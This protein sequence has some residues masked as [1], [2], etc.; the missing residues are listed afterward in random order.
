MNS[1]LHKAALIFFT[2]VTLAGGVALLYRFSEFTVKAEAGPV[3]DGSSSN[4]RAAQDRSRRAR[5]SENYGRLPL[6]F[7]LNDGQFA[8]DV[9][10]LSRGSGYNL[11][12]T[13]TE[14]VLTLSKSTDESPT[15]DDEEAI[16]GRAKRLRAKRGTARETATVR[17]KL[18]GS[19]D[20]AR[21]SGLGELPGKVNYF[22]GG[23]ASKWR[24][25]IST[26]EKV[27]YES[28][29]SGVDVIY[30]GNQR[31]L[32]YD[33]I[34]AP[35]AD[36]R[37][38]KLDFSGVDKIEITANGDLV[39]HVGDDRIKQHKSVVYQE[40]NG[41]RR[42]IESSYVITGERRVGFALGQYD[43]QKPLVI[44]P[45]LSYS[46]YLGGSAAESGNSITVD[47]SGHAYITGRTASPDFPTENPVQGVGSGNDVFV[48]KLNP[49]GT[50]LIFSTYIGGGIND[51]GNGIA[52]DPN[53]NIYIAGST[54]SFNFPTAGTPFQ[55]AK[56]GVV[57][58]LYKSFDNG[59][60]FNPS[61]NGLN[62]TTVFSIALHPTD[63]S[64]VFAGTSGGVVPVYR[65]TDGGVNWVPSSNG[66]PIRPV[67]RIIFD[68]T[69]PSIMYNVGRGI[70]VYKSTNGGASWFASSTGLSLSGATTTTEDLVI[71]SNNPNTLYVCGQGGVYKST[72]AGQ[73]WSAVNNGLTDT[74]G[75]NVQITI[76]LAVDPRTSAVYAGTLAGVYRSTDG[77]N[78]VTNNQP[79]NQ[80]FPVSAGDANS[81]AINAATNPSTLYVGTE[82]GV[83][84]STDGLNWTPISNGLPATGIN[85]VAIDPRT[86][87]TTLY[88]ATFSNGVYKSIDDGL[89]WTATNLTNV[90]VLPLALDTRTAPASLYAGLFTG[91]DAFVTK[92]NPTGSALIYSTYLGGGTE[93]ISSADDIAF[94]IAV[95]T[96]GNAYVTG[97]TFTGDFPTQN[98]LQSSFGDNSF[99]SGFVT[100]L[101]S[102]GSS[103]IYSTYLKGN[104]DRF[105]GTFVRDI[106]RGIAV[107]GSGNA[108]VTGET[109]AVDFP[110][111]NAR[112]STYGGGSSDAFVTAYNATGSAYLYS[113]YLGGSGADRGRSIAVDTS[114]N[115]YV[116]GETSSTNFPT[117][118][119]LQSTYGG[120][121]DAFVTKYNSSGSAYIF[122]TYLGG[123]GI[124]QG[125][126]IAA[127]SGGNS[128]VTGVTASGTANTPN[129]TGAF[130]T[131]NALQSIRAGGND[132]FVSKLNATGNSLVYSTYLG[133]SGNDQGNSIALDSG[134]NA[135]V[136]GQTFSFNFPTTRDAFSSFFF[137]S[138]NNITNAFVSKISESANGFQLT[139]RLVTNA[140]AP[141]ADAFI[142]LSDGAGLFLNDTRTDAN[143]FYQFV[144]V[145]PGSYIVTPNGGTPVG[146]FRFAPPSAR[147]DNVSSDQRDINFTGTRVF[148]ISGSITDANNPQRGI[149][150]IIVTLSGTQSA[151]ATT[152]A[153]GFYEFSDLL[154]G[155]N[156]TVTPSRTSTTGV[157]YTFT[158]PNRVYNNLQSD[159]FASFTT[160]S[161]QFF[162]VSGRVTDAGG[163]PI[164]GANVVLS[165]LRGAFTPTDANGNYAFANLQEG[166][167]YTVKVSKPV[168]VFTP[169]RGDVPP[170]SGNATVN[171]TAAPAT[172][173]IS[174]IA[175]ERDLDDPNSQSFQ[176]DIFV[177]NANGTGETNLTNTPST[178]DFQPAWSP[179]GTRLAF[180]GDRDTPGVGAD[181]YTMN[182]D[183]TNVTRVTNTP[184]VNEENPTW[185]PDGTRLAF[186]ADDANDDEED[187]IFV[188][189]ADG[190]NRVRLTNTPNF[191]NFTPAWSPDG[192]QIAFVREGDLDNE[193]IFVMNADGTN[194]VR[195]TDVDP[196]DADQDSISA[197][198]PVYS[199]DGRQI[200][201]TVNRFVFDGSNSASVA[202]IFV[203]NADG[204][205]Q[206]NLTGDPPSSISSNFTAFSDEPTWS[207]DGT[208][209]G[210]S[211]N[212]GNNSQ[213]F[214]INTDGT[215]RTQ[216]TTATS[217]GQFVPS[218]FEPA[219]QPTGAPLTISGRITDAAGTPAANVSVT[220]S[221]PQTRTTLTDTFGNYLLTNLAPGTYTVTPA[222][223][224]FSFTP[225]GNTPSDRRITLD[226]TTPILTNINFTI[227]PQSGNTPTPPLII[228]GTILTRPADSLDPLVT[229]QPANGRITITPRSGIATPAFNAAVTAS[230]VDLSQATVSVE[231]VQA[232]ANGAETSFAVGN[233]ADNFLRFL[234][235]TPDA[236]PSASADAVG[237]LGTPAPQL[238]FQ[239]K[240][241]SGGM[242]ELKRITY[243]PVRH[244]FLRFRADTTPTAQA[245]RGF[246]SFDTS[247]CPAQG[248]CPPSG[249]DLLPWTEEV[250][251]NIEE[252][253]V[254]VS[255]LSAELSSGTSRAVANPGQA[256]FDNFQLVIRKSDKGRR[257]LRGRGRTRPTSSN[258]E[259]RDR[260]KITRGKSL[261]PLG[262]TPIR[263]SN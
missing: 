164:A 113:T 117:M 213:I 107:D 248:A 28:V 174:R 168:L 200:A 84:K 145:T 261:E 169:E 230:A 217:N 180:V 116:T 41:T 227:V 114:G 44:D 190:T 73:S 56:A 75:N 32:E 103:L 72:N 59:Q 242:R 131:V 53:G 196:D 158:P 206:R 64:I 127:D 184:D 52:L 203:M 46:S 93:G 22:I 234:I 182:A 167:S 224:N 170:L 8:S 237:G 36:P 181:I 97:Q 142:V 195:L 43:S 154:Q 147:L 166:E 194:V 57:S 159:Q 20:T 17:M 54:G 210:Y 136:V 68:P 66:M 165:G 69:N 253:S 7:E 151:T 50:A 65:S 5:I 120:N 149:S 209:I 26:Y 226:A 67:E 58:S 244:R 189:N 81:L 249:T 129:S 155:G 106:G 250:R 143:G 134:N 135:Y 211:S 37:Q 88:A 74:Q 173:L 82:A 78:W 94:A 144:S 119:A 221:G 175:F 256:I 102:S 219:W 76:S 140:G 220:L 31:Q 225:T 247:A 258:L 146:T 228:G 240:T 153:D 105:G 111:A 263:T 48:T 212:I 23:D 55:A 1:Q 259:D 208:K 235:T 80:G 98:A 156:Y 197:I 171:F 118:N 95:D 112:Q 39:I 25:N 207:P 202:N 79:A 10:F 229:I 4:L 183:G 51:E 157:T 252:R 47:A 61:G 85:G 34:V 91:S 262:S 19:T 163:N 191:D 24:T 188:I 92:L 45:I 49:A 132:A 257:G 239:I 162:T 108:Y 138:G 139:G 13:A 201:F 77:V 130:P 245:P 177:I 38:I 104:T 186:N 9:K 176:S 215:G 205:N 21:V 192:R 238:I 16:H 70:P 124:D 255:A 232:A 216:I 33:F 101:N 110:R 128:F 148:Q 15:P 18:V 241:S 185:S 222:F 27:R 161:A 251:S 193:D 14:A 223:R 137:N 89:N 141:I 160:P 179:D 214:A 87:P 30:Y 243:D 29:Y 12:L 198:E 246:I 133:G 204:T 96:G 71:D 86:S 218:S 121:Q 42:E 2:C 6:Q 90:S 11:F 152:N 100:K 199:P 3:A 254:Q 62:A 63:S 187:Q 99:F 236:S 35:N 231:I 60:T 122:S 115:A 125:F 109:N 126:G 123:S 233:N 178:T 172:G 40:E 260:R 83:Y 150:G